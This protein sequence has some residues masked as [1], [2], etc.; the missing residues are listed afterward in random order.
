MLWSDF[1]DG[2]KRMCALLCPEKRHC[3]SRQGKWIQQLTFAA[4]FLYCGSRVQ[5]EEAGV[6]F[7]RSGDAS[8]LGSPNLERPNGL[9]ASNFHA[10]LAPAVLICGYVTACGTQSPVLCL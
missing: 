6:R 10:S 3:D 8:S 1:R 5:I 4:T 7:N 2:A 9:A